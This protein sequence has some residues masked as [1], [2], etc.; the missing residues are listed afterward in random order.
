MGYIYRITNLINNKSYIGYSKNY[1][2]RW[3]QHENS[4]N[5]NG[6]CT[7]LKQAILK[8]GLENFKFELMIIC[9]DEAM[10]SIEIEYIKKYNTQVPNGYNISS[11][12][13]AT[14]G[15]TG[16]KHTEETKLKLSNY[17]KNKYNSLERK[18]KLSLQAKKQFSIEEN[19]KK[20]SDI[21]KNS[22]NF[23][24]ALNSMKE[25]KIGPYTEKK[26][27]LKH[28]I[29]KSMKKYHSKFNITNELVNPMIEKNINKFGK[30]VYQYTIDNIYIDEYKSIGQASK[31]TNVPKSSIQ[32]V[33][34]KRTTYAG[35]F[36]WSYKE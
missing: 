15:F 28:L 27:D 17:F 18:T 26:D 12:G 4:I 21:I 32:N 30:K 20:M 35:G 1:K 34:H 13:T 2:I 24:K 33:L 6:G 3:K 8:Y 31:A 16:K 23:K 25:L 7:V 10:G 29:S 19:R 9:F 11:G 14:C 5:T 36:L 22:T